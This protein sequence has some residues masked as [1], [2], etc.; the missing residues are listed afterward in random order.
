MSDYKAWS[1]EGVRRLKSDAYANKYWN[2]TKIMIERHGGKWRAENGMVFELHDGA[3]FQYLTDHKEGVSSLIVTNLAA[4]I[5]YVAVLEMDMQGVPPEKRAALLADLEETAKKLRTQKEFV[6]IVEGD[7][8]S[9]ITM[10][11]WGTTNWRQH[12][13]ETQMTVDSRKVVG[14]KFNPDLIYSGDT[15]EVIA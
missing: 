13:K 6:V 5:P 2:K 7:W 11:R 8:L 3:I 12:L 15:F 1:E 9:K 14:K 4:E 10:A